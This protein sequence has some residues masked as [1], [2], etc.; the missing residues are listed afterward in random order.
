[1]NADLDAVMQARQRYVIAKTTLEQRLMDELRKQLASLS[2]QVDLSVRFAFNGGSN[3]A[4]ILR[5]LGTKD[6]RTIYESLE[7]TEGVER[8]DGIDPLNSVYVMSSNNEVITATYT[9]H[10][11]QGISGIASFDIR[12][13]EDATTWL[14]ARDPLWTDDYTVRNYVVAALDG[15]QDGFYYKEAMVWLNGNV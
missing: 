9:N 13:M 6:Y 1:M 12:R 2:A 7:R 15:Q 5:A 11:P 8:V 10:G 4:E 3:K 14:M